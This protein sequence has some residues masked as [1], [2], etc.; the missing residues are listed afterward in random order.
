MTVSQGMQREAVLTTAG[1]LDADQQTVTDLMART[2]AAVNTLGQNWF[3]AD[4]TQFAADWAG[5]SRQLPDG[6][7]R[8]RG[9]VQ[10]GPRPGL[11]PA[12]HLDPLAVDNAMD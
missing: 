2:L 8:H 1:Q 6:W 5:Y 4:S 9:D 7:R 12:E 11:G 10:D 3:G